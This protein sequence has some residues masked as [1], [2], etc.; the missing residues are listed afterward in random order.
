MSILRIINLILLVTTIISAFYLIHQRYISRINY[1][2]LITLKNQ[3]D[4]LDKEYTKLELEEATFSS[5][6]VLQNYALNKLGLIVA[7]KNH[8]I[9][10]K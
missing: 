2:Q 9:G 8:I 3:K 10:M 5:N 7:D 6:L 4:Y 1:A